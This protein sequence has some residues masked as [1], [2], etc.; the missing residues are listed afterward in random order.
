[1]ISFCQAQTVKETEA[2]ARKNLGTEALEDS[3]GK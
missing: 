2:F 3:A 1:M